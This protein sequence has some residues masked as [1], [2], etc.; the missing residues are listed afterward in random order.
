MT[1]NF[2]DYFVVLILSFFYRLL[3]FTWRKS[4]DPLPPGIQARIAAGLP[5]I[6]GHLHQDDLS[7]VGFYFGRPV[8]VMVSH[9]KDGNLLARFFDRIGFVVA[10]GSSSRGATSGF[11]ELHR[12]ACE[13]KLTHITFAVDGPRGPVGHTKNGLFK[14]AQL[15]DAPVVPTIAL[16]S[17]RWTLHRSWSKTFIP[18]LFSRVKVKYLDPLDKDFIR[19][20][21][22]KKEYSALADAFDAK[23]KGEK[24][25]YF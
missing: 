17:P 4:E 16:A 5:T 9:S 22:S 20:K 6:F 15:L 1:K 12:L 24:A 11:L 3:K 10:R 14:L 23:I 13:K 7:L 19:D 21:V 25:G 2:K 18:K 8:G